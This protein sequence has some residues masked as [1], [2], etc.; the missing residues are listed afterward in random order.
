MINMTLQ[1]PA[2]KFP[3]ENS[4]SIGDNLLRMLYLKLPTLDSSNTKAA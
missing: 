3:Y 4:W 2:L 1:D